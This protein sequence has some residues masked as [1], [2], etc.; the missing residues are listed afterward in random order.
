MLWKDSILAL[1]F[2]KHCSSLFAAKQTTSGKKSRQLNVSVSQ[3]KL[4]RGAILCLISFLGSLLSDDVK[5]EPVSIT[6]PGSANP[7]LAGMPAGSTASMGDVAPAQSPAEVLGLPIEA[8]ASL[9]FFAAGLTAHG[10]AKP[11]VGPDGS[12]FNQHVGGPENGISDIVTRL[13]SLQ[14]V[15]LGPMQPDLTLEPDALDFSSSGN[16]LGGINY[17]SLSPLL[18]QV[19]FIGDGLIDGGQKQR[20][21]VPAGATRLFLGTQDG[22][23]WS[24]N[25]G[26]LDVQVSLIPEPPTVNLT[27]AILVLA[28]RGLR[29]RGP[30]Y[31]HSKAANWIGR[32]MAEVLSTVGDW[33]SR[34]NDFFGRMP[35][36]RRSSVFDYAHEHLPMDHQFRHQTFRSGPTYSNIDD[37]QHRPFPDA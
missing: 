15:F 4:M 20:I 33:A 24:N 3:G 28:A 1:P 11:L 9:M 29:R 36:S 34:R 22:Y 10:P 12:A 35:I 13:N 30:S 31:Q 19:F 26:S 17:T 2:R 5:A 8:G 27:I 25:I 21:V 32:V 18:K 7:W 23:G 37:L 16:V 14:G 6:V